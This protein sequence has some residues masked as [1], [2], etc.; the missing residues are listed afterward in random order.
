MNNKENALKRQILQ[1]NANAAPSLSIDEMQQLITVKQ[2]SNE[3]VRLGVFGI[4]AVLIA[5][6]SP[7]KKKQQTRKISKESK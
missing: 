1:A 2:R 3:F 4:F 5:I 7:M 6:F